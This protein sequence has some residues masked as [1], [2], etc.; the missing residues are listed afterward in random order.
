MKP[1]AI[2]VN[3]ARGEV[4]DEAALY[5][6]LRTHPD[7]MAGLGAWCVEPFRH[8]Q[9]RTDPPFLELPNVLGSPHNSAMVPNALYEAQR[10]ATENVLRYVGG[11][12]PAGV[13]G[14]SDR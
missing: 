14:P 4:V 12:S 5:E 9:F 1:D 13:V 8:G 3:V 11:E 7:F 2:L 10:M 6:R